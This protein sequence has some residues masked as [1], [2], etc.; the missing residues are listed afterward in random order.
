[1]MVSIREDWEAIAFCVA[2]VSFLDAVTWPM[3]SATALAL[4]VPIVGVEHAARLRVERL[5]ASVA[6]G[7]RDAGIVFLHFDNG[8]IRAACFSLLNPDIVPREQRNHH[9][10]PDADRHQTSHEPC[11]DHA[12][13]HD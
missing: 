5:T 8:A 13:L 10:D 4:L 6:S 1:M 11:S 7:R 9:S 3:L 12:V 2:Q